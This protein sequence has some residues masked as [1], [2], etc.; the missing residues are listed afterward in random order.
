MSLEHNIFYACLLDRLGNINRDVRESAKMLLVNKGSEAMASLVKALGD[1]DR[2]IQNGAAEVLRKMEALCIES[3]IQALSS[4][5]RRV[6]VEAAWLLGEFGDKRAVEPLTYVLKDEDEEV[7]IT[8][9]KALK[10]IVKKASQ[11]KN[12][13]KKLKSYPSNTKCV[14]Y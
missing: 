14:T 2:D 1:F 5:S 6:R 8:A 7:R 12:R 4:E 13:K 11:Y 9:D 10:K 3:L